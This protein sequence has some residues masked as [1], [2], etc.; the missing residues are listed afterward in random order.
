MMKKIKSIATV[1]LL[2][3]VASVPP[4]YAAK[5]VS[6]NIPVKIK[7]VTGTAFLAKVCPFHKSCSG[8]HGVG[9]NHT[10]QFSQGEQVDILVEY[11]WGEYH[12]Y[13]FKVNGPAS[14]SYISAWGASDSPHFSFS[15]NIE[16][17]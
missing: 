7:F 15:S 11:F 1:L 13:T 12:E 16:R 2:C 5:T 14:N 17:I 9:Y 6:S 8:L 10:W 3:S 4:L